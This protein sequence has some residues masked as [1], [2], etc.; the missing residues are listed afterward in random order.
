MPI[1]DPDCAASDMGTPT[2]YI[3]GAKI[4]PSTRSIESGSPRKSGAQAKAG[5]DQIEQRKSG[6]QHGHDI[7]EDLE[8]VRCAGCKGVHGGLILKIW[9]VRA[10][11]RI[12]GFWDHNQRQCDSGSRRSDERSCQELAERIRQNVLK[13]NAV[14][15]EHAARDRGEPGDHENEYLRPCHA[16]EVR[17]HQDGRFGH[18]H[19]DVG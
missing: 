11:F 16:F 1:N 12:D 9:L 18:A 17:F 15:N 2:M 13:E 19:E 10:Q 8:A 7:G 3:S 4:Q 5:I 6:D 14:E